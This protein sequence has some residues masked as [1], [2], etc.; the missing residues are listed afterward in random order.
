MFTTYIYIYIYV[1]IT[2]VWSCFCLC[3]I[4]RNHYSQLASH[5]VLYPGAFNVSWANMGRH[6]P[7]WADSDY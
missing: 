4:A 6:G 3:S 7:S 2:I 5:K 1:Y